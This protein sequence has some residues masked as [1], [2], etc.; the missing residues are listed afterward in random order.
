MTHPLN[1]LPSLSPH[2]PTDHFDAAAC[3]RRLVT[4]PA[5]LRRRPSKWAWVWVRQRKRECWV[6]SR[7]RWSS[8]STVLL[9]TINAAVVWPVGNKG[10]A[11]RQKRRFLCSVSLLLSCSAAPPLL[12]SCTPCTFI[13]V[14]CGVTATAA[15]AVR[16]GKGSKNRRVAWL[17]LWLW[18]QPMARAGWCW[19]W[20]WFV[21]AGAGC[22]SG[23]GHLLVALPQPNLARVH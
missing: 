17:Q 3:N 15:Q 1:Q 19:C 13:D 22:S 2:S 10:P 18:L 12:P 6:C 7:G 9:A 4:W 5:L 21:L 11:M 14:G 20:C 16:R 8:C 23:H